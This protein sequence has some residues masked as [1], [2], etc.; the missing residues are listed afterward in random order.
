MVISSQA[1]AMTPFEPFLTPRTVAGVWNDPA[2]IAMGL[3]FSLT[4]LTILLAHELGHYFACRRYRLPATLPYF[5]PVPFNFG[6]LG[7]FIRIKAPIRTKSE[8]FDVGIAG[9]ISGFVVLV[10]FLAYGVAHSHY[11]RI[12]RGGGMFELGEPLLL[13]LF[14]RWFHG[15]LPSGMHL[16]LH[17]VAVGAWLG[18]FATALNL[19]PIGQLDGGHIVYATFGRLQRRLALP[20]LVLLGVMGFLWEGW[21]LWCFLVLVLGPFHPPVYDE[22]QPLDR[23]RKLLAVVALAILALCFSPVPIAFVQLS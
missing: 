6:T 7:A 15:P 18:L 23:K 8:L 21:W 9:P 11:A 12:P 10:P 3:A 2:L 17:P 22:S 13:Q 14:A 4:A 19:L 16:D 5:L 1:G 20:L